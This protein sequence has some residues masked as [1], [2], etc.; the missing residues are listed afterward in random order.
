MEK[1]HLV[2]LEMPRETEE[3]IIL[4]QA[5]EKSLLAAVFET[6]DQIERKHVAGDECM[7]SMEW[8]AI[9]VATRFEHPD[10]K[11]PLGYKEHRDACDELFERQDE[12]EDAV[13]KHPKAERAFDSYYNEVHRFIRVTEKFFTAIGFAIGARAAS[14]ELK[15][16]SAKL[17]EAVAE[18]YYVATPKPTEAQLQML[19]ELA[20]RVKWRDAEEFDQ[21]LKWL[22]R[23]R[24]YQNR[25][26][27][28][29]E[30]ARQI[31]LKDP[32]RDL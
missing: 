11:M 26:A 28:V 7:W 19:E 14:K 21:L 1:R 31:K 29:D 24:F 16:L 20:N 25:D 4:R 10:L 15:R 5:Q 13:K 12:L 27:Y 6:L 3:A 9:E 23:C 32:L 17:D 30:V 18:Q 22:D 8:L 2:R